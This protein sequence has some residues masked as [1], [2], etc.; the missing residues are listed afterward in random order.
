MCIHRKLAQALTRVEAA[1]SPLPFR[2]F[3]T[4]TTPL[5]HFA[6]PP[7][8]PL[9]DPAPP[10][11][12]LAWFFSIG[13]EQ[14]GQGLVLARIQFMFSLSALFLVTHLRTVSHATCTRPGVPEGGGR[15]GEQRQPFK[16]CQHARRVA[17]NIPATHAAV[18]GSAQQ[19][20]GAEAGVA[21]L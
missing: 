16:G 6:P 14:R 10:P 11:S 8:P 5:G 3:H 17:P 21:L 9:D 2:P 7:P 1:S 20:A 13:L 19:R 15:G 12:P 18:R 4:T